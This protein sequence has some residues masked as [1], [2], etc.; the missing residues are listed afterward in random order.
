MAM[1]NQQRRVLRGVILKMIYQNHQDQKHRLDNVTVQGVLDRIHF[2]VSGA[3]VVALL[4]D[5]A[6]RGYLSFVTEK[7][8]WTGR[9]YLRQMQISPAGIDLVEETATDQAVEF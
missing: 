5:L 3:E 2:S 9:V 7:N 1:T 8:R 6:D 4:Q